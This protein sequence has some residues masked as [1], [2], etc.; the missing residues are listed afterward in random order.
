MRI[1][2]TGGTGFIGRKLCH[3]LARQGYQLTLLARNPAK[4]KQ[5]L[6]EIEI[7]TF[8]SLE[9]WKPHIGFDAVINLAGEPIMAKR[10]TEHRKRILWDSRVGLTAKLVECMTLVQCKPTVF[11][12]GSA[13]GIYGNQ[14]DAFLDETSQFKDEF[15]HR[16]CAAWENAALQAEKLDIRVCLL[17][18]GLVIGKQ[19]GFL[20]RMLVPF[21]LGLGGRIGEGRQWMSWIHIEDHIGLT[22]HLLGSPKARGPYNATAPNPVTNAEFTH[23][24]AKCLHRRALLPIPAWLLKLAMGEMAELLLGSQRVIP[25]KALDSGFRFSY[26]T[27]EPALSEVLADDPDEP[28]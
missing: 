15:G 3:Q 1:L 21:K 11:I 26:E 25:K 18:T 27:L 22:Q 2:I 16:L 9:D 12:S 24:L 23:E 19:G 20:E 17:R 28:A 14:G 6:S 8:A 13:V 5:L 4:A 10:W 7:D